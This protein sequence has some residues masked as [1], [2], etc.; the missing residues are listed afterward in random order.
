MMSQIDFGL[1]SGRMRRTAMRTFDLVV[2]LRD[3]VV[4]VCEGKDVEDLLWKEV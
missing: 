4:K 3:A 1:H 2:L